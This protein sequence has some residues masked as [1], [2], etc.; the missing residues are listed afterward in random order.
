MKPAGF[1]DYII[2]RESRGDPNAY[3]ASS[4][5][6]GCAQIL[7]SHF[8]PGGTCDGLG[9]ADCWAKMYREQG[10]TPWACTPESGCG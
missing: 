2:W 8:N 4:G 9:Y 7:R 5:A 1:P 10:L 3:N 6:M